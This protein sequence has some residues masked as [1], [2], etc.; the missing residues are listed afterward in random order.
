MQRQVLALTFLSVETGG[1]K[2]ILIP[3]VSR[4]AVPRPR[5]GVWP[6]KLCLSEPSRCP[7]LEGIH[8]LFWGALSAYNDVDMIGA[9]VAQGMHEAPSLCVHILRGSFGQ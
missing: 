1:L 9:Y 5:F 4:T 7:R 6:E 3:Q 2:G 8:H